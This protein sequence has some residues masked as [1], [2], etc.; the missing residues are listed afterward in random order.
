MPIAIDPELIASLRFESDRVYT[1]LQ[2]ARGELDTAEATT[3]RLREE[4]SQLYMS[5]N[6]IAKLISNLET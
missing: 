5:W 4:H 1:M 2:N 3:I 6:I